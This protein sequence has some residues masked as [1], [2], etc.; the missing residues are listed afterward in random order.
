MR[1][2]KIENCRKIEKKSQ[3]IELKCFILRVK[4]KE[5]RVVHSYEFRI[6]R[7]YK[8]YEFL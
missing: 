1:Q 2:A 8:P 3:G 6:F 7:M 5:V 4:N